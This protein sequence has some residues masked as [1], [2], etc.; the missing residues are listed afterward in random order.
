MLPLLLVLAFALASAPALAADPEGGPLPPVPG[1]L[2]GGP[3]PPPT[4]FHNP[5]M[6]GDFPDPSVIRIGGEYWAATTSL[7]KWAP[8]LPILHSRDLVNWQQVGSV[9]HRRPRWSQDHYWAPELVAYGGRFLLFY[10]AQRRSS[11]KLCIAVA[12]A[13]QPIGPWRDH[14]PIL[15]DPR[16]SQIDPTL[17]QGDRGRPYLVWKDDANTGGADS[18]IK[19]QPLTGDGLRV[20]GRPTTLVRANRAEEQGVVEAPE[21]VPHDGWLYLFYSGGDCCGLNADYFTAVARARRL[22]GPWHKSPGLPALDSG[23][24]WRSPGHGAYVTTPDGR[25]FFLHHAYGAEGSTWV[26]R[27]DV[28]DPIEWTAGGWPQIGDTGTTS[29]VAVSPL[30]A[31]DTHAE[32]AVTDS[33]AEPRLAPEWLW[34]LDSSTRIRVGPQGG[35]RL[36][37]TADRSRYPLRA[38]LAHR[39]PLA[40]YE[41]RAVLDRAALSPGALGGISAQQLPR[42]GMGLVV[43]RRG[44]FTWRRAVGRRLERVASVTLPPGGTATL[45]MTVMRGRRYSF[46]LSLDGGTWQP[47]GHPIDARGVLSRVRSVRA[48]LT[49]GGA[50]KARAT[51]ESFSL[52]P[53]AGASSPRLR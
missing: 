47:V 16:H 39:T 53:L 18:S 12:S 14:G 45:G 32:D 46:A 6:A 33:F 19:A 15:C 17:A 30:G 20:R 38:V 3:A 36:E 4:I 13:P 31:L 29:T 23:D 44:A 51:F 52:A 48:A 2:G 26:G 21:I 50:P 5:V 9:F 22:L 1:L 41:A 35:S 37:L 11:R 7:S 8:M 34:P 49:A 28:L 42:Y 27:Q 24:T 43:G 10:A 25:P 40:S